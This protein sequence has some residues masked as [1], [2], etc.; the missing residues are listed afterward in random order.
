MIRQK[1]Q[2]LCDKL[3]NY[4]ESGVVLSIL[5]AWG[6]FAG[7]IITEYAF[8]VS[9]DHLELPNFRGSFHDA[10]MAMAEFGHL[11]VMF[12][13]IHPISSSSNGVSKRE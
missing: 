4:K 12:P 5:D 3:T 13:W 6:A 10:F 9:Y 11:A 2:V 8:G 1:L 7:D